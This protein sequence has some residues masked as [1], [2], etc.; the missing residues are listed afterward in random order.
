MLKA[1][2]DIE[3]ISLVGPAKRWTGSDAE[4]LKAKVVTLFEK[5]GLSEAGTIEA[6]AGSTSAAEVCAANV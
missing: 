3:G 4:N 1:H 5:G 6:L 2:F